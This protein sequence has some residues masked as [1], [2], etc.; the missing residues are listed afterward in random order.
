MHALMRLYRRAVALVAATALAVAALLTLDTSPAHA[1]RPPG[2]PSA[3]TAQN[4]LNMLTVRPESNSSTYDRS[5]FPHWVNVSG[6]CTARQYV[7][8]RD[9]VNV[10]TGSNCQPTS[11]NWQSDFD[12][13]WTSTVS[14]ATVD[15]VVALKEAWESGAHAWTTTQRRNFANDVHSP[16]LWIA[17]A[18]VNSSKGDRDPAQWIPPN[19]SVRCDYAKAWINVKYRYGLSVDSAEK[20]ALQSQ[21]NTYC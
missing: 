1:V 10:V 21:L 9:G 19:V 5:L 15:H 2:I 4:Q 20:S 17:T 13:V 6:N 3:A 11:G 18:S 8:H 16:Q 12:G 14:N 7:L